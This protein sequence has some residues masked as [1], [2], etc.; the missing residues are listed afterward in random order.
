MKLFKEENEHSKIFYVL[1]F[2][3]SFT[4][5]YFEGTLFINGV[6]DGNPIIYGGSKHFCLIA[7]AKLESFVEPYKVEIEFDLEGDIKFGHMVLVDVQTVDDYF[8]LQKIFDIC[9]NKQ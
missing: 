1:S 2:Q 5:R 7:S 4:E 9:T 6:A 8:A 3:R